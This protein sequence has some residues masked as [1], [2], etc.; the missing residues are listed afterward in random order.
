MEAY[1]SFEV[2]LFCLNYV[3]LTRKSESQSWL[4]KNIKSFLGS[5]RNII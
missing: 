1:M 3:V 5:I 2:F 4:C